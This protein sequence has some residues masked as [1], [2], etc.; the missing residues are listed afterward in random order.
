MNS[1]R[2]YGFCMIIIYLNRIARLFAQCVFSPCIIDEFTASMNVYDQL[3]SSF[4]T[5]SQWQVWRKASFV[6]VRIAD[7]ILITNS[8]IF[9]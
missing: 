4:E 9:L 8:I 5:W 7:I 6:K 1:L 3:A 2:I